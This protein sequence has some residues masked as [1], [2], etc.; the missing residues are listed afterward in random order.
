MIYIVPNQTTQQADIIVPDQATV[1]LAI[2]NKVRGNLI[3]GTETDAQNLLNTAQQQFLANNANRFQIEYVTIDSTGFITW[4][5]QDQTQG[6]DDGTYMV[7]NPVNGS[8]TQAS[9][10]AVAL[11]INQQMQQTLLATVELSTLNSVS[12]IDQLYPPPKPIKSK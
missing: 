11:T 2:Q 3:I 1:D 4:T 6:P 9:S 7:L 5:N 10:K 8:Y 12:T